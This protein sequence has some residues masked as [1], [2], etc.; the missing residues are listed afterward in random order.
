[1]AGL[2]FRSALLGGSAVVLALGLG[3]AASAQGRAGV[4]GG[5]SGNTVSEVIVTGSFIAGTPKDAAIPVAVISQQDVE[6]QGSPSALDLIRNLPVIGPVLGESN[7]G[8]TTAQGRV[9]GGT[10][11]LRGLGAQRTLVLLNG[12]RFA[13]YQSDTN[14]LPISAIGRIEI[15]KDGAAATYGSDAIGGVVNFI[16]RAG[17]NGLEAQADYRGVPGS[18][19]DY[20]ASGLYG[21][22]NDTTN[23]LLSLGYQHRSELSIMDRNWTIKPYLV[24]PA[25]WSVLGQPGL[26][27]I[28][29]T[30]NNAPATIGLALDANCAALGSTPGFTGTTPACYFSSFPYD[31]LVEDQDFYQAYAEFNA[32]VGDTGKFHGEALYSKSDIPRMRFPPGF[33][34]TSGPNGPGSVN[35][36]SVPASN[37][38]FNTFLSQTGNA[39]LIGTATGA[40]ATLWRP[41][42]AGGNPNTGGLGGNVGRRDYSELHVSAD[43]SGDL[44]FE[45]VGYDV[46]ATFIRENQEQRT[47]DILID[48]LQRALNGLGGPACIGSTPGANG[49]QYFNPFSNA[50]MASPALGATNPG[51]VPANANPASLVAWLYDTQIFLQ[52]QNTFVADAVLSGKLPFD[53]PGGR[54]GWAAGMQYRTIQ[55]YARPGNDLYDS[56]VTPCPVVGQ[57]SCA[58]KTGPYI[59]LGQTIPLNLNQ[60][61]YAVFGELSIPLTDAINGQLSLRYEDYGGLTG[62]TTN[63]EFRAKWQVVDWLALRGSVGTSFRGPPSTAVAPTGITQLAGIVAAGG[64]FRSVDLFGNPAVGPE[65]AFSY[66]L[67]AIVHA[68]G[69]TGTVDYWSYRLD[70]QIVAVPANIIATSVGGVGNGS[71]AVNCASPLRSLITFGNNNVCTQGVTIGND[72]ARVRSDTTNGPQVRTDG[73]DVDVNYDVPSVWNG[74]LNLGAS[75][76]YVFHYNQAPFIY[77]GVTVSPAFDAV[78][79]ANY[80]RLPGAMPQWRGQ[81]YADYNRGPHNL[82]WTIQYIGGVTDDR[83]PTVAQTGSSPNCSVATALAGTAINCLLSNYGVEQRAYVEHD[84]TYR[85]NLPLQTTLTVSVLNILDRAPAGAQLIYGYDPLIGNPLGRTWKVGVKKRF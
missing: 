57:S 19:G 82:R 85:V 24:N 64:S 15:L 76:S 9:G 58:L 45:G 52:T 33:I 70:N 39:G 79:F 38:G 11:N 56:R 31:N 17:F 73:I 67:G 51:F 21:W 54:P 53:L 6:K 77:A 47:A 83:G 69:F 60:S 80:N 28:R 65:K 26:F 50:Y 23:L 59:F 35:V 7:Q 1:M 36:F 63:P 3:G 5:G 84:V 25:Q 16:T 13:G 44:P 20:T 27:S 55:T 78:G 72:I 32:K 42:G 48:R 29:G 62:S 18:R 22:S 74:D 4:A 46:R 71:Q 10:I 8:S 49:C 41:L 37:P 2:A 14:L 34:P 81:V 43:L 61:V 75:A 40:L 12:T 68:G 66:S 30:V